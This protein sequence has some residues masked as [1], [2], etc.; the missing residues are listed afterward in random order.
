MVKSTEL[1]YNHT[2][3]IRAPGVEEF[4]GERVTA[5]PYPD[6]VWLHFHNQGPGTG[7]GD[8]F[9]HSELRGL[10]FEPNAR[11]DDDDIYE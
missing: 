11:T 1:K 3:I 4:D 7:T 2:Y 8:Y 5:R 6:R 9:E 10:D